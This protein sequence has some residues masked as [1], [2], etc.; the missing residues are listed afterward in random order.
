VCTTKN[1][2][3]YQSKVCNSWIIFC[4]LKSQIQHCRFKLFPGIYSVLTDLF[5][6]RVY[7]K[8]LIRQSVLAIYPKIF[9]ENVWPGCMGNLFIPI[10]QSLAINRSSFVVHLRIYFLAMLQ[11][12]ISLLVSGAYHRHHTT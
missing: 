1:S 3:T 4:Y 5:Y 6:N 11:S 12:R 2:V 8:I 10:R 7:S 9:S